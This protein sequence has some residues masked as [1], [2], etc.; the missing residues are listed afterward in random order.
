MFL[1][2]SVQFKKS[3]NKLFSMKYSPK[4]QFFR[5]KSTKYVIFPSKLQNMLF[6]RKLLKYVKKYFYANHIKIWALYITVEHC[7]AIQI[8]N[9]TKLN[10]WKM[11]SLS[12]EKKNFSKFLS[13]PAKKSNAK[14]KKIYICNTKKTS[15]LYTIRRTNI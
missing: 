12:L 13:L 5:E 9:V 15:T 3:Q 6:F 8:Q 4:M 10:S 11:E 1:R 7:F 2:F 14:V